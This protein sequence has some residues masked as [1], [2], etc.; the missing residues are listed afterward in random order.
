MGTMGVIPWWFQRPVRDVVQSP[1]PSAEVRNKG[2]Y[3]SAPPYVFTESKGVHLFFTFVY[4]T[5]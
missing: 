4:K 1:P 3:T 2:N 5:H